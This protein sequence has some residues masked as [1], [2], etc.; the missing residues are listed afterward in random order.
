MAT[1]IKFTDTI[2]HTER[3][4]S[5]RNGNPR[6]MIHFE[7]GLALPTQPDASI[8]YGIENPEYHEGPVEVTK[9]GRGHVIYVK[10]M[11]G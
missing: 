9:N 11:G 5:S 10:P 7:S 4:A 3:M 2:V 8:A 6:F 1:E